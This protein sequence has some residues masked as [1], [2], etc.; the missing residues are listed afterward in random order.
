[1]AYSVNLITLPS[2][3]DQLI[4]MG[5]RDKRTLVNRKEALQLRSESSV[6]NSQERN[7]ELAAARA[8]LASAISQIAILPDGEEKENQITKKMELD[9]KIRKLSKSDS[10]AGTVAIL[11]TEYDADLL[12]RQITGMDAFI[13]AV[14]DRKALLP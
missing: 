6:E 13:T 3:A 11:E 14:A 12:D 10:K 1:M 5:T 4:T 2:E 9:V 8:A 7:A